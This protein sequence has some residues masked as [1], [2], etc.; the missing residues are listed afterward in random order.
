MRILDELFD[1]NIAEELAK[2]RPSLPAL[3]VDE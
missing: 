1:L 3:D 2:V